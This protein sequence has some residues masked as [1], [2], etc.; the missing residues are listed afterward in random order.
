MKKFFGAAILSLALA[1]TVHATACTSVAI[2]APHAG[3]SYT[4]CKDHIVAT[5]TSG[6]TFYVYLSSGISLTF[7]TGEWA[8]RTE[9]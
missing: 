5:A 6:S 3:V 1:G 8:I 4:I 7:T 9:N 2:T